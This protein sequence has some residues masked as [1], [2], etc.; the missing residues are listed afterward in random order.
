MFHIIL[1]SAKFMLP[2]ALDQKTVACHLLGLWQAHSLKNRWS[3]IAQDTTYFLQTPFLRCIRHDKWD[4]V[5]CVGSLWAAVFELHL[6][7]I[8]R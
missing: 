2:L 5:G 6:F 7:G 8:T 1:R 3:N 4:F